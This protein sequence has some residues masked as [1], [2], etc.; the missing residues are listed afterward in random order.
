MEIVRKTRETR[1]LSQ[2]ALAEK[3]GVSFRC[4][5]QLE[6]ADHNWRV[7]SVER[8]ARALGLPTGALRYQM[9][10]LFSL[11]TDSVAEVSLL[12]H[13]DGFA[14][15][16]THLFNFVDRFR[17]SRDRELVERPP[18]EDLDE[19]LKA[20]IACTVEMLCSEMETASPAWCRGIAPLTMPWF[21]S[22][23]ENLK[24]SALVESP[25]YFRSRNIFVLQNF[26]SRA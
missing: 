19:R 3:S 22:G 14:S 4:I 25:A 21:V 2:R 23:I 17:A 15:W 5:Q 24:A 16:P 12:I 6:S 8:V 26:L 11:T 7:S 10:R 13:Q 18:I 9:D 1:G 20:L